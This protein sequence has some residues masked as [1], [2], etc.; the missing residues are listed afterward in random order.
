MTDHSLT[1]RRTEIGG[2]RLENDYCVWR[3]GRNIG[4]IKFAEGKTGQQP[5]WTWMI[6]VPLP[7]P[8]WGS[9]SCDTLEGAM[10]A[11]RIAW[12]TFY[13]GLSPEQIRKWH[14]TQEAAKREG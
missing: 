4:R 6:N 14:H 2:D 13:D 8:T 12:E 11:F 9:G 5:G 7:I 3:E 1:L 10:A